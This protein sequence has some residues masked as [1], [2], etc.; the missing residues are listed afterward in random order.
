MSKSSEP[1][2]ASDPITPQGPTDTSSSTATN[3]P[4]MSDRHPERIG[5]YGILQVL[6]AGGMGVVYLAE[7]TQ[8]VRRR[9]ALK[10]VKLGM[11]TK[12]VVARFESERQALAMMNHPNVA[13]VY[14]AGATEQGRPYFVM[15]YVPGEP[16]TKYCDRHKLTTRERLDLFIL[17]CRAIQHAHQKGIIHRD[18][19]PSNVLVTVQD[20]KPVPKVIDFGVAKA[21]NQRL[22]EQTL[23]TQQGVLIGTPEYM[24]PE[25]AEMSGLDID[26]RTDIYSLGVLL[27]E[28]LVGVLP[29]DSATLRRA[30][31]AEIARIIREVEPPKPSTRLS[32]LGKATVRRDGGVPGAGGAEPLQVVDDVPTVPNPGSSPDDSTLALAQT[33]G[34]LPAPIPELARWAVEPNLTPEAVAEFRRT[35]PKSLLRHLRGDLD[36]IVMKA[37]DKDRTRRYASASE[38]AEDLQRHLRNETV[39][40]GRPSVGYR[41]WKFGRR[42]RGAVLAGAALIVVLLAGVVVSTW[43]AWRAVRAERSALAA[44]DTAEREAAKVKAIND[45]LERLFSAADPAR[46]GRTARVV[47]V[48]DG[49]EPQIAASLANQPEVEAPVRTMLGNTLFGLGLF[50]K[51][52]AMFE[53]AQALLVGRYGATHPEV[54]AVQVNLGDTYRELGRLRDAEEVL[55][56]AVRVLRSATPGKA[57][58]LANGLHNLA[59]TLLQAQRPA[60]SE[61][62]LQEANSVLSLYGLERSQEKVAVLNMEGTLYFYQGKIALAIERLEQSFALSRELLGEAHPYTIALLNNLAGVYAQSGDR[63]RAVRLYEDAVQRAREKLGDKHPNLASILCYF[64]TYR[65]NTGESDL[66]EKIFREALAIRR[67][68]LG[69]DH[70]DTADTLR[71]IAIILGEKKRY[72]DCVPPSLE[73]LPVFRREVGF[74]DWRTRQLVYNLCTALGAIARAS[75]AEPL[76]RDMMAFCRDHP[77]LGEGAL[78]EAVECLGAMLD[79]QNLQTDEL[80]RL[81][82]EELDLQRSV[83]GPAA[84]ST[85]YALQR[86]TEAEAYY[87]QAVMNASGKKDKKGDGESQYAIALQRARQRVEQG[88]K[89]ASGGTGDAVAQG[90]NHDSLSAK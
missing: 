36:W 9:V 33:T 64:A 62:V 65:Y 46:T 90:V 74:Q 37:M 71:S 1:L 32:S 24:S 57:T 4:F 58:E 55:R 25:Q 52:A 6:G 67:E 18:I 60:E 22:T 31:Y 56:N 34:K 51:A 53:K 35:D 15:E 38:F 87:R 88:E 70:I 11:D 72:A 78:L 28:L 83:N 73:A 29:F 86:L 84:R 77:E 21:T 20:G 59:S 47:D 5:P 3:S 48:I 16:I 43:Q 39:L 69:N 49:A 68:R 76:A 44:R 66:A 42:N 80:E 8:P 30:G 19:K 63:E 14:D 82:R 89:K 79:K 7:Q 41:L 27:Y 45:F 10:L 75:E 81:R 13:A 12:E 17:V 40:A 50:D 2:G 54:A 26:T 23:F 61:E 85:S